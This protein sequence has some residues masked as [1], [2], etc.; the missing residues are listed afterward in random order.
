M[1]Q[2]KTPVST[3]THSLKAVAVT[4]REQV[5]LSL[6]GELQKLRHSMHAR[7]AAMQAELSRVSPKYRESARN[8]V[9]YLALRVHD[10]RPVQEQL[11][12]LGLSSLGRSESHVLANLDKVLGILHCLTEQDWMDKSAEEPAGSVSRSP[13]CCRSS[14]LIGFNNACD[15]WRHSKDGSPTNRS[16]NACTNNFTWT[17]N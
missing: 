1:I 6:I 5:C 15:R 4:T 16:R 10:L 2:S 14:A 12:W 13:V 3:R 17:L 9:H 8:L 11:A 7:E